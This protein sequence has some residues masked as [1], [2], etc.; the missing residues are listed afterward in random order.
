MHTGAG[1]RIFQK[2]LQTPCQHTGILSLS[3]SSS[4]ASLAACRGLLEQ[5]SSRPSDT[6][7][8][9]HTP[10][11]DSRE[12]WLRALGLVCVP[13][14]KGMIRGIVYTQKIQISNMIYSSWHHSRHN[15]CYSAQHKR[16]TK[17]FKI[18]TQTKL[19][20]LFVGFKCK[21]QTLNS[22]KFIKTD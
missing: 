9:Q 5:N 19:M 20:F 3:F 8:S 12:L 6:T 11:S 15:R 10:S 13:H 7:I 16:K 17:Y 18:Q 4:T 22:K 21:I 14:F 1:C 2:Q